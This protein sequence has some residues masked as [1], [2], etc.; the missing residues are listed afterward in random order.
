[1]PSVFVT[2]FVCNA[3]SVV[4]CTYVNIHLNY[5]LKI[6]L[7][8]YRQRMW[9]ISFYG[10]LIIKSSI[11]IYWSSN[12]IQHFLYKKKV[13]LESKKQ[14]LHWKNIYKYFYLSYNTS[15]SLNI[16]LPRY[17]KDA[18]VVLTNN[19]DYNVSVVLICFTNKISFAIFH[20]QQ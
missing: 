16:N 20:L 2:L 6:N 14:S 18:T 15:F 4:N 11:R 19:F 13:N 10:C 9:G 8:R 12:V 3:I 7:C 5:F 17:T 1:M